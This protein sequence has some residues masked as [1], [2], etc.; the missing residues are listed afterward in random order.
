M[1]GL[2]QAGLLESCFGAE[3]L[4]FLR[5]TYRTLPPDMAL[6]ETGAPIAPKTAA[7]VPIPPWTEG[8]VPLPLSEAGTFLPRAEAGPGPGPGNPANE[9]T[10]VFTNVDGCACQTG[11]GM[12][13]L[14][15]AFLAV[16]GILLVRRRTR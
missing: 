1:R 15:V 6:T 16:F 4:P 7:G 10:W 5:S 9:G 13:S 12:A 3:K 14:P 8:G 2:R 11:G